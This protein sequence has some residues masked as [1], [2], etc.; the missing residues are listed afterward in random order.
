M[1]LF[2]PIVLNVFL[3]KQVLIYLN[4]DAKQQFHVRP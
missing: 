2:L 3:V 1:R 4:P